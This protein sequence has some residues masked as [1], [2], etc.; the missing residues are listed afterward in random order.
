[1]YQPSDFISIANCSNE[2]FKPYKVKCLASS[3]IPKLTSPPR[4]H[5]PEDY[6]NEVSLRMEAYQRLGEAISFDDIDIIWDELKDRFGNPPDPATWLY[7]LTRIRVHAALN[8][9][10]LLKNG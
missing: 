5:I 9:F 2:R 10:T 8:G 7:H 3:P 6:V 1:M 4:C